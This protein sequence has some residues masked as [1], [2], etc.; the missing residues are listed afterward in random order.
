MA[1]GIPRGPVPDLGAVPDDAADGV[2]VRLHGPIAEVILSRP[3]V[4]NALDFAMWLR[5]G[6]VFAQLATERTIRVILVRGAG[7]RA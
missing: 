6:Q 3:A 2:A 4:H 5:I 7:G 1:E